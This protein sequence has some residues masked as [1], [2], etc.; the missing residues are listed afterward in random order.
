MKKECST[1]LSADG[2]LHPLRTLIVDDSTLLLTC[3]HRLLDTQAL[4]QVVGTAVNGVE[5]LRKAETLVPDLVLMDLHMP[6]MDGLQATALLR[7][8]LRHTRIIILTM[9]ETVKTRAAARAHGAHGFVGKAELTGTLMA[10]IRRVFR[11]NGADDAR[12]TS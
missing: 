4:V 1:P 11:L 3:L 9:D 12:R 5:A 8:R 7:C 2:L 6:G 10:E